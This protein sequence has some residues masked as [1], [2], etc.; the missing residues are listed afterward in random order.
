M[1]SPVFSDIHCSLGDGR[2]FTDPV[3][4]WTLISGVDLDRDL[5][6][7]LQAGRYPT[8][9]L[10]EFLHEF[11]HHWCF[12]SPV[13]LALALLQLRARRGALL[14]AQDLSAFTTEACVPIVEDVARYETA[15]TLLR[16]LT[17]G[18]ALFAEFDAIPGNSRALSTAMAIAATSFTDLTSA[19]A[20]ETNG[21]L[22]ALTKL[23]NARRL[24][25]DFV[26]R[27]ANLLVQPLRSQAGGYLPGYLT[28]KNVRH[29][30]FHQTKSERLLDPDFYMMYLRSFFYEDFGLVATLL[31][32]DTWT[33]PW[34]A[35]P[36]DSVQSLSIY[37]QR[38][39]AEL[40]KWTS[41]A[42]LGRF[43][44]AAVSRQTPMEGGLSSRRR[45][46]S[47]R[48]VVNV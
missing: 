41:D 1:S 26:N 35:G 10:P 19:S 48:S 46:N 16:P 36:T 22:T 43:E 14:L 20:K 27:K 4:N 6:N 25:T 21:S 45:R 15:V 42:E 31:D 38:R 32:P 7:M 3:S 18:L 17:E 30:L 44:E 12:H 2:S 23:L 11:L 33:N 9:F 47:R 34:Q 13:G 37:F 5:A 24:S 8:H 29:G 39:F 28:V 40:A